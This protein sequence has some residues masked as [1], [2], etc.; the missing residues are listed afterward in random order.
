MGVNYI[1]I[2]MNTMRIIKLI[3][4]NNE[5]V[6]IEIS[7]KE[8][9]LKELISLIAGVLPSDIKGIKDKYGNY[10]TISFAVNNYI[11]N[12][13]FSD[14]YYLVCSRDRPYSNYSF[15]AN[16]HANVSNYM[17][18]SNLY[19][20]HAHKESFLN[21]NQGFFGMPNQQSSKSLHKNSINPRVYNA[22]DDDGGLLNGLRPQTASMQKRYNSIFSPGGVT[23]S[24]V[25]T[26][27]HFVDRCLSVIKELGEQGHLEDKSIQR[28]K[29]MIILENED[30]SN[31]F[32]IYHQEVID[33][34][35][36][37]NSINK[38][39]SSQFGISRPPSP[40][41][42]KNK[43]LTIVEHFETTLFDDPNDL[44]LLKNL[45]QYDNEFIM[46]AYEVYEGDNDLENLIDSIRRLV[47]RYKRSSSMINNASPK[48][49]LSEVSTKKE[50]D[51]RQETSSKAFIFNKEVEN[52]IISNLHTEQ[53]II[54]K[55][56]LKNKLP[57]VEVFINYYETLGR[58]DLL[59]KSIKA[60]TK[61]FIT[62]NI[63]RDLDERGKL[64]FEEQLSERNANL[65]TVFKKYYDHYSI[66]QLEKD[67]CY[68]IRSQTKN[69]GVSSDSDID[70]S[71]VLAKKVKQFKDF[72]NELDLTKEDKKVIEGHYKNK[73]DTLKEI[74]TEWYKTGD[75]ITTK[76]HVNKILDKANNK[77]STSILDNVIKLNKLKNSPIKQVNQSNFTESINNS[78]TFHMKQKYASFD[79]VLADLVSL[80][81]I[82]PHQHKFLFQ[83]YKSHDDIILSAWEVYIHNTNLVDLIESIKLYSSSRK[84]PT[85]Q[86]TKTPIGFAKNKSEIIDF[87][88]SKENKEKEEIKDKQL[89]IIRL[90]VKEGML[91]K[92]SGNV[93]NEMIQKENHLLISAF[94]IFS[95]NKDH[96][97]F[98]ETLNLITE[99][100][101]NTD[102]PRGNGENETEQDISENHLDKVLNMFEF[103]KDEKELIHKK[104]NEQDDF[105]LSTLEFYEKSK[106]QN[107]LFDNLNILLGKI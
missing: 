23:S 100:Y 103:S 24:S 57:E 27:D 81:K 4:P 17:N 53:K 77:G 95:V 106:D 84:F 55:Y 69:M 22:H 29:Q 21:N 43:L 26:K 74:M 70:D 93:I 52:Y 105:L 12:S 44:S 19:N 11:I 59:L 30:I 6:N 82:S 68:Y 42:H 99:I 54:F 3:T 2:K 1:I 75:I 20:Q 72:V 65:L 73:D 86:V 31:L 58:K 45:I 15:F 88:K 51:K 107:E 37:L 91:N 61:N 48:K 8:C 5:A 89:H 98:C 32:K 35:T 63:I 41:S 85:S 101:N 16:N 97:D 76:I 40:T 9:E 92:N 13:D 80:G 66:R 64:K 50:D 104:Y 94:E 90:L 83:R 46:A 38:L 96:W 60:F 10:Y 34:K 33:K 62:N 47:N 36:F 67:I 102:E 39:F 7:G 71:V 78:P 14:S 18:A 28:L 87:L 56:G 49:S 79:D 25:N